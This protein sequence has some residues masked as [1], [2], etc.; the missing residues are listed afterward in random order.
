MKILAAILTVYIA[1]LLV[2]PCTDYE[3]YRDDAL[4]GIESVFDG[5]HS[6]VCS[7]FC[8]DHECHTHITLSF[9]NTVFVQM[10][11]CEIPV[12]ETTHFIPTPYFAIWQPPKIS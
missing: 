11:F 1:A 2:L 9:V 4:A 10:P 7:P 5:N 3:H 8:S 6:D 12:V